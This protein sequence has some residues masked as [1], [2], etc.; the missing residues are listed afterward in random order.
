MWKTGITDKGLMRM[1][2]A[3]DYSGNRLEYYV[4]TMESAAFRAYEEASGSA[5]WD[6]IGME[7]L[8]PF[9][10]ALRKLVRKLDSLETLSPSS[11]EPTELD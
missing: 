4:E 6:E 3:Q 10:S 8:A 1:K 5:S 11:T 9:R 7:D 2:E